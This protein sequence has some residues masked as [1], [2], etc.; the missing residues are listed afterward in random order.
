MKFNYFISTTCF[1]KNSPED[2][3]SFKKF[4]KYGIEFSGGKFMDSAA[5]TDT[6]NRFYVNNRKKIL[7]HNYFPPAENDFV[8]NLASGDDKIILQCF[9][10]IEK[11]VRLCVKYGIPYYSLH[12]GF[13]YDALPKSTGYFEFDRKTRLSYGKSLENLILNF[14]SAH[15]IA[16]RHGVKL[17]VENLFENPSILRTKKRIRSSLNC[18]FEEMD[19][20][21]SGLPENTGLLLDLGHLNMS[22]KYFGFDKV[23]FLERIIAKYGS[24]IFELHISSNNGD[25]DQH[26]APETD[27]WQ[28]KALDLF[29]SCPGADGTGL[30]ITLEARRLPESSLLKTMNLLENFNK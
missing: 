10:L 18:T 8:L 5:I 30:N 26:L 17:A 19:R 11:A 25:F 22:S 27:D 24:R 13:L 12:P 9:E 23:N 6:I 21:L 20:A 14:K 2:N 29:K 15:E 1:D 16:K 28:L 3:C 7:I 4:K